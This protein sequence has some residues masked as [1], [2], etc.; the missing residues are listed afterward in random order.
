MGKKSKAAAKPKS[1]DTVTV[2][3]LNPA[4]D[5]ARA[6]IE[7]LRAEIADKDREYGRLARRDRREEELKP[8]Q[9]ELLK[10]QRHLEQHQH[11]HDRAVRG[12]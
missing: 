9:V 6:E 1:A 11:P 12:A 4:G 5:D 2:N 8:Y 7:K 10:L 3:G